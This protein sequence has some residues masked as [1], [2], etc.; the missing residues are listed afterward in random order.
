MDERKPPRSSS[1]I[2]SLAMRSFFDGIDLKLSAAGYAVSPPATT[3]GAPPA[4]PVHAPVAAPPPALSFEA[5][6]ELSVRIAGGTPEDAAAALSARGL[7]PA[8]WQ[9]C[10]AEH[11]RALSDDLNAGRR[12]RW[13][14]LEV[15]YKEGAAR[16]AGHEAGRPA[17]LPGPP[18]AP[19][20]LAEETPPL[21]PPELR[22]T[23]RAADLGPEMWASLGRTPFGPPAPEAP[24]KGKPLAR[25]QP[26]RAV[27]S[28]EGGET[29][30]LDGAVEQRPTPSTPFEGDRATPGVA[31]VPDLDARQFV[32]LCAR[33]ELAPAT[34]METL[35]WYRVPNEAALRAV[36]EHWRHPSRRAEVERAWA[37][38]AGAVRRRAL[39]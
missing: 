25:T 2:D 9:R 30:P 38:Y 32:A 16:R 36:E 3:G 8:A 20:P 18:G 22:E 34:R 21:V 10:D 23:T 11:R 13:A 5:W 27:P 1:G 28:N 19:D 6:A 31:Y 26:S 24:V 14:L 37:E 17:V 33:L 29:L 12:R 15:K 35:R 39:G 4:P 7:T